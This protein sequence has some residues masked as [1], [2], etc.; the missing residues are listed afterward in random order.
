MRFFSAALFL[1]HHVVVIFI[2]VRKST[3]RTV[4]T[5]FLVATLRALPTPPPRLQ[6]KSPSPSKTRTSPPSTPPLSDQPT[7]LAHQRITWPKCRFV[8]A[9][10]G[11]CGYPG[12]LLCGLGWAASLVRCAGITVFPRGELVA[13]GKQSLRSFA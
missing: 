3:I 11:D 10:R 6:Q 5:L 13:G 7:E 12:A 8:H 1:V 9:N 2:H 4:M